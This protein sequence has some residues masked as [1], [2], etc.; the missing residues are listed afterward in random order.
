LRVYA[1]KGTPAPRDPVALRERLREMESR[2]SAGGVDHTVGRVF[3]EAAAEDLAPTSAPPAG[4]AAPL[5]V[6]ATAAAVVQDV[7]PR[8]F[9]ALEPA[10]P[11][12][13]R[14]PAEVTVT[15]VRWP[16]T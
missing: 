6:G 13:R 5:P 9:A 12:A 8:Y 10:R 1:L 3:L 16:F 15:L 2:L 4:G 11:S 7:L 14:P